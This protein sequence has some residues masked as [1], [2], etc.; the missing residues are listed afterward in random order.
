MNGLKD[1]QCFRQEVKVYAT[2]DNS[3]SSGDE[4]GTK[5]EFKSGKFVLSVR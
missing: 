5:N 3:S 1:I 4:F 2:G